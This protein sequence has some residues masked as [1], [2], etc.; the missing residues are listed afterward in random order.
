MTLPLPVYISVQTITQKRWL[1]AF[2]DFV[3]EISQ[4]LDMSPGVYFLIGLFLPWFSHLTFTSLHLYLGHYTEIVYASLS[5]FYMVTGQYM[6]VRTGMCFFL[7]WTLDLDLVTW[8]L[9][10]CPDHHSKIV[11]ASFSRFYMVNDKYTDVCVHLSMFFLVW[12][13]GLN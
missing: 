3:V 13:S 1:I 5:R 2:P 7:I 12:P 11:Y 8:L 6:G 10:L 9:Q 4:Y